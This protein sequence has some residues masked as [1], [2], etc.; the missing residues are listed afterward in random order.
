M[1]ETVFASNN[2]GKV[3]EL[4]ALLEGLPIDLKPQSHYGVS[5]AEETGLTFVENALIKARHA[6]RATGLP[7]IA[8]DSGLAVDALGGAPGI[9]SA[10]YAG[11]NASDEENN[12]LLLKN[13]ADVPQTERGAQFHAVVV[14]LR[15]AEDP[16]PII[17]HG[18]WPGRVLTAPR[19]SN[20]FGYDP[21]FFVPEEHLSAAELDPVSKNRLSHRGQAVRQLLAQL[22]QVLGR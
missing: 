16:I 5:A 12:A 17:S 6:S 14:Y 2:Q 18:Q 21:L 15:H 1:Q 13:L 7:A 8:D 10:R 9:Y 19:G 11:Q 20:G 4:A 22:E 3:A